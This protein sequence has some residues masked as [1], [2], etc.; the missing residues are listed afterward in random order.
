VE[1]LIMAQTT[2]TSKQ[3]TA[4]GKN[5][6]DEPSFLKDD[7]PFIRKASIVFG[8]SLALAAMLAGG[9]AYLNRGQQQLK[10]NA[11]Q[12]RNQAFEKYQQATVEKQDAQ[13]SQPKFVQLRERGF[14]GNE[15]RLDWIEF[16]QKSQE[17]HGLLPVTYE[18]AAQQQFQI[19]PATS[20]GSFQLRGSQMTLRL[21]LWHEGDLINLLGDLKQSGFYVP[22]DCVLVRTGKAA[23]TFPPSAL[24]AEC[25]LYW[26]TLGAPAA[27]SAEL[28][29]SAPQ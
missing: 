19:D 6:V 7:F 4:G 3:D 24:E 9:T 26:L 28:G 16:V 8:V 25:K 21:T 13:E 17:N 20:I 22:V 2:P 5:V 29:A 18:I 23:D 10:N 12:V 14:V 1:A 15:R 11:Q 27:T